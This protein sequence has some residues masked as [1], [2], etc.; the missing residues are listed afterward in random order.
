MSSAL[1][2]I[3]LSRGGREE[4]DHWDGRVDG[5]RRKAKRCCLVEEKNEL[6]GETY[7]RETNMEDNAHIF[8]IPCSHAP[9][10][11]G[12]RLSVFLIILIWNR[13]CLV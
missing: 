2:T 7:M 5:G 11:I 10:P 12:F 13:A 8:Y 3:V 1:E 4:D 6:M 9:R